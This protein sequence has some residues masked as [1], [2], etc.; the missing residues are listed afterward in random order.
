MICPRCQN[1]QE[2]GKFCGKCGTALEEKVVV[3]EDA[4]EKVEQNTDMD[5]N[6]VIVENTTQSES[7]NDQEQVSSSQQANQ[8]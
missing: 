3:P 8:A 5:T 4:E 7:V 2:V 1:E 6:D